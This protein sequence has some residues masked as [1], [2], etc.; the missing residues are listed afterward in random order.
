MRTEHKKNQ[1]HQIFKPI[2][3]KLRRYATVERK[4]YALSHKGTE[5]DK[6]SQILDIMIC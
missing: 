3:K 6:L 5:L 2:L 1:E 4:K